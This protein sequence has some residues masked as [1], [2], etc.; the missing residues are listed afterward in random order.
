MPV[1][2][3]LPVHVNGHFALDPGRRGLWKDADS[4]DPLALWN[5]MIKKNVLAPGY[6]DLILE[7]RKLMPFSKRETDDITPCFFPGK[8]FAEV[9]LSWYHNLFPNIQDK[10]WSVL[11]L[12]LYAFLANNK[13][14]VLP[15]VTADQP[16]ST[17]RPEDMPRRIQRWLPVQEV[18]VVD[19]YKSEGVTDELIR[20]L[21]EILLPVAR[22]SPKSV[23]EGFGE[24]GSAPRIVSPESVVSVL[25][26]FFSS[27]SECKIGILLCNMEATTVVDVSNLR[28]LIICCKKMKNFRESLIGLPLLLTADNML[29]VFSPNEKVYCSEF[30]DLLPRQLLPL[31]ILK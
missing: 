30:C 1:Q 6:A 25:G 19:K 16:K 9:G 29:R 13:K 26:N 7:A 31:F 20:I 15:V 8:L 28:K 14:P 23:Q 12:A 18:F 24:A 11:S 17:Q 21:L 27:N 4:K 5:R 10:D 22:Y 2:T 3:S